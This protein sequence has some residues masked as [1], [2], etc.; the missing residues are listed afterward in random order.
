MHAIECLRS[1]HWEDFDYVYI[2]DD[3]GVECDP[4]DWLG[5]GWSIAQLDHESGEVAHFL[6]KGQVDIPA[7]PFPEDTL[8]FR[9]RPFS[10]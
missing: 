8:M 3:K 7:E 1:P 10:Y 5:N 2:E 6:L 4:L 9:Q